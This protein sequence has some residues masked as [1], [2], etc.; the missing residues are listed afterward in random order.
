M[1]LEEKEITDHYRNLCGEIMLSKQQL[2]DYLG[3][4]TNELLFRTLGQRKISREQLLALEAVFNY[5]MIGTAI[6]NSQQ[7]KQAQLYKAKCHHSGI[8]VKQWAVHFGITP[9]GIYSRMSGK[10]G[11]VPENWFALALVI[12]KR[13]IGKRFALEDK[14][15]Q[16]N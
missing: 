1:I 10:S 12:I 6:S 15:S 11:I 13:Q 9:G 5:E 4:T 14:I 2:A 7:P 3:I 16:L 8:T